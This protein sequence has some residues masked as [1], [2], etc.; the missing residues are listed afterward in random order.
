MAVVW[1]WADPS[2]LAAASAAFAKRHWRYPP[3]GCPTT[4]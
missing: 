2:S 1:T 3:F 4:V